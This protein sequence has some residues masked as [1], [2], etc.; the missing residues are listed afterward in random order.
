MSVALS[1]HKG[2]AIRR[3]LLAVTLSAAVPLGDFSA[4]S[5]GLPIRPAVDGPVLTAAVML[6][7]TPATNN[8]LSVAALQDISRLE[9]SDLV[10]GASVFRPWAENRRRKTESHSSESH[11]GKVR[12]KREEVCHLHNRNRVG[13]INCPG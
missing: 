4:K 9:M 2:G 5:T 8:L 1:L 7:P 12:R 11:S 10:P 6:N 13:R 3:K